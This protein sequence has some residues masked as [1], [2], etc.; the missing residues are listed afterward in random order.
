M[1]WSVVL[2]CV[3]CLA[4]NVPEDTARLTKHLNR[5]RAYKAHEFSTAEFKSI[6]TEYLGWVDSRTRN[7]ASV[8]AL[9][10]ELRGAGLLSEGPET[11]DDQLEKTYAGYL[12]QIRIEPTGGDLL[13]IKLGIYT[14]GF[15]NFD[16]TVVLYRRE[17]L[18]RLGWINAEPLYKHGY[19]LSHLTVGKDLLASAW[20]ASNCASN[21]NGGVFRIEH[22]D[23]R[24]I[25]AQNVN[26][27][28]LDPVGITVKDAQ[29]TFRYTAQMGEVDVLEREGIASY[30]IEGGRAVRIVPIASTYGGFISEWLEMD[31]KE[32]ARWSSAQ[33]AGMHH[34][35]VTKFKKE[36]F[37]WAHAADCPGPPAA[38][39]IGIWSGDSKHFAAFMIAG[40]SPMDLR[41]WS[42]SEHPSLSCTTIDIGKDLSGIIKM[43]TET[44][45]P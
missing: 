36:N 6:Q 12:G 24:P 5:F 35:L 29:V 43:P 18:Q 23:T 4:G 22:V 9:N 31:D 17:P 3:S 14:G 34:D 28:N 32:A 37:E 10:A 26:F 21:W 38:R 44:T 8:D 13:A 11:L 20:F 25:L 41:L 27:S 40:L 1:R 19:E 33:A 7:G 16:E 45:Q 2:I 15:C 30:R 42:V 39:E